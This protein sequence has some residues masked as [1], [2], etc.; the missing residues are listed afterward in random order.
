MIKQ[1]INK[2]KEKRKNNKTLNKLN[3]LS[4]FEVSELLIN[5]SI[6][7]VLNND[8]YPI[9]IIFIII[10]YIEML[11]IRFDLIPQKH[12][13][14]IGD[15][16]LT[17][18]RDIISTEQWIWDPNNDEWWHD[19]I[20]ENAKL[21]LL[22]SKFIIGC[23]IGFNFGVHERK[24]K[25][26]K[27]KNCKTDWIGIVENIKLFKNEYIENSKKYLHFGGYCYYLMGGKRFKATNESNI[28]DPNIIDDNHNYI[29]K[30]KQNDIITVQLDCNK[31]TVMIYVNNKKT[32]KK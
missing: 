2:R 14:I 29:T 19:D 31:W 13:N 10:R 16:G 6:R 30:W 27:H 7:S 24:I 11:L 20:P 12:K 22:P 25:V 1:I 15:N 28:V 18:K 8:Y 17:I 32:K 9:D 5:S 3:K 4:S 23:S 21:G 26:I